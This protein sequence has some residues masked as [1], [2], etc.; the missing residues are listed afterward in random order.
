M[1]TE[2]HG[3]S[4]ALGG[5]PAFQNAIKGLLEHWRHRM[6]WVLSGQAERPR[7]CSPSILLAQLP[8]LSRPVR[9]TLGAF[10]MEIM[11]RASHELTEQVSGLLHHDTVAVLPQSVPVHSLA[12]ITRAVSLAA[13]QVVVSKPSRDHCFLFHSSYHPL[14]PQPHTACSCTGNSRSGGGGTPFGWQDAVRRVMSPC[15]P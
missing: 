11:S 8:Q 10:A 4:N 13:E 6:A 15:V 9:V 2:R 7:P 12:F 1:R 5:Q 3:R 14:H